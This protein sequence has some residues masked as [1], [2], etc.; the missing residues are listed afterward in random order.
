[1]ELI[2][3]INIIIAM[4]ILN[5]WIIRYDL[6][7]QWRGGG[8]KNLMEEFSTYGLP[9]WFMYF[10]GFAKISLAILLFLGIWINEFSFLGSI[11]ISVLM[12]GAVLMHI[13]VQDPLKK[14]IPAFLMLVLSSCVVIKN[15]I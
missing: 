9:L 5:V 1:M 14:S 7:T 8:S 15:I 11:G 12:A 6:E 2:N 10:V 4:G 3:I 13:K